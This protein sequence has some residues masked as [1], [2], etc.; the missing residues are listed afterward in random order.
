MSALPITPSATDDRVVQE[1][2]IRAHRALKR[3]AR[4]IDLRPWLLTLAR[5][6]ALDEI[7]RIRSYP[8]PPAEVAEAR[9]HGETP[10]RIV[11][12]RA[13]LREVVGD[14]ATLP[15]EQRHALVRHAVDGAAHADIAAELGVTPAASRMLV[16]RARAELVKTEEARNERCETVRDLLLHAHGAKR[17]APAQAHRHLLACAGCR[18]YRS[19][20]K[21]T[22]RALRIL[23]PGPMLVLVALGGA[24]AAKAIG[25]AGAVGGG[26][27]HAGS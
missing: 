13:H 21:A 6:C 16:V 1:A 26:G 15:D 19:G 24:K 10:E 17:R 7:R 18:T 4:D 3:D 12:R 5:N 11:A 25:G 9:S 8:L 14:V 20:L 27:H 2:L 23:H 22:D